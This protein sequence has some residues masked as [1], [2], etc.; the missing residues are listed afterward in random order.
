MQVLSRMK[1]GFTLVELLVVIAII[2]LLSSV[3]F[4]SLNS[5]RAKGRDAR[6]M[7]DLKNIQTALN[8]Y[9]DTHASFPIN[10]TPCCGYP[11]SQ[12]NFLQE[13]VDD[14]LLPVNPKS[15]TSPSNPYYYYDYGPGNQ[16]GTLLVTSLEAAPPSVAGYAGTCRPWGAGVNWCDQRSSTYYCLC[17][18]Y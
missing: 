2:G 16:I 17:N 14:R 5:A 11:D 9:Y 1:K 3:I 10:R 8:V 18:P 13:L 12:S 6:R 7:A 4:A 15:P